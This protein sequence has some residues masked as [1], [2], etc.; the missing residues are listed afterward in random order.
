MNNHIS[1]NKNKKHKQQINDTL[2][3]IKNHKINLHNHNTPILTSSFFLIL[4]F[5]FKH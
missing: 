3:K 4:P 1:I 5:N 2:L